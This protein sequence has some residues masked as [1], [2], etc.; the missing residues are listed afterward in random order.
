MIKINKLYLALRKHS[1]AYT[2]TAL[3]IALILWYQ[4]SPLTYKDYDTICRANYGHSA[5]Y[6]NCMNPYWSQSG[7]DKIGI[8]ISL[9]LAG[10][11]AGI[12]IIK[13]Y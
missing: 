1:L 13:R 8:V 2:A 4:I 5:E 7:L 3:V 10:I 6:D 9:G 12:F 11:F